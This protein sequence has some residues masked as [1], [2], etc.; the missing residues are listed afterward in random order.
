MPTFR[1]SLPISDINK[2]K[3]QGSVT[4]AGN[5]LR[6][7]PDTPALTRVRGAVQ[8]SETGFSLSNVQ[9]QALGGPVRLEGGMRALAANAP[10][11]E[12]AVQI[13]AQGTATAEG[14]QQT[15]QLGMLSQLARRATGSAP[16]TLALS[17]RRGVPELQ[18]NTSLQGLALALPPPL[19]KTADSSLPLRFDNQV[20]RESLVGLASSNGNGSSAPPLRDQ[21]VLDLG[22]LGS[23][24]YLRD[25][26]GP[27][28]RVL[29][30][31][32]GVGLS[33]GE[34]APMPAQGVA[35][36]INQGKLDVDAWDEVLT[37][38]LIHI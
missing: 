38:S 13:R 2:S 29:R 25:L 34:S 19:G 24:T 17:F 5:E 27:Q 8:F 35:A 1:L 20:A 37:L 22:S 36:N 23:A 18:V 7:T 4:L 14:L 32:I 26:S 28:P 21:I 12:S 6:I 15:P 33:N 30:G 9:A 3:V 11:T 16:Y 31:A 10:A